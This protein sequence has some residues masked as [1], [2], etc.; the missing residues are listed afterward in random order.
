MPGGAL[1][2][3]PTGYIDGDLNRRRGDRAT[4]NKSRTDVV[5]SKVGR[6]NAVP[7]LR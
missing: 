4:D 5:R 3:R 1:D 7:G 2:G 6:W